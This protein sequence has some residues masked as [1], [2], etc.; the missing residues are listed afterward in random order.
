MEPVSLFEGK[1]THNQR[2][3]PAT[4]L[5]QVIALIVGVIFPQIAPLGLTSFD[6]TIREMKAKQN[7]VR[8]QLNKHM[9][10]HATQGTFLAGVCTLFSFRF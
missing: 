4:T 8:P 10:V 2:A 1:G 3:T 9:P 5:C 7:F 6:E